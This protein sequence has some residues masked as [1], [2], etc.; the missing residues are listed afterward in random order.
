M[1]LLLLKS[2][3]KGKSSLIFSIYFYRRNSQ[4]VEIN[5]DVISDVTDRWKGPG[6][7]VKALFSI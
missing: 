6:V 4:H 1:L 5:Y 3:V 2:E 7:T